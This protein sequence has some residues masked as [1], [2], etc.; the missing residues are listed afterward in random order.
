MKKLSKSKQSG[1]TLIELMV[2]ITILALL[3]GMVMPRVIGRLRQAKP[4]KAQLDI[5][6]IKVALDMYAADNGDY[7]TTEQGLEAL[8]RQPTSPPEPMNW[9]GPYVDPTNFL[10]PW[11][12][13]YVYVSPGNHEGYDYDLY[14]YGADGQEGGTEDGADITNWLQEEEL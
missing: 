13:K 10:D 7:P 4:Q 12:N 2:V 11:G 3:G 6:Q 1:F 8:I 14:S 9:N 5:N